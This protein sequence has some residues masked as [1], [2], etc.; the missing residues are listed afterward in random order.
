[1][2]PF[3]VWIVPNA[4]ALEPAQL[5]FKSTCP[6]SNHPCLSILTQDAAIVPPDYWL[7]AEREASPDALTWFEVTLTLYSGEVEL[8]VDGAVLDLRTALYDERER[9]YSW[10]VPVRGVEARGIEVRNPSRTMGAEY[11]V[12]GQ[13]LVPL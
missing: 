1:M 11:E 7:E 10:V 13:V 6:P 12:E 8:T 3:L 5:A 9:T 4:L 2:I